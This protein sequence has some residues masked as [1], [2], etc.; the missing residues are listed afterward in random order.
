MTSNKGKFITNS[1]QYSTYIRHNKDLYLPHADLA[2]YQKEVYN[3]DVKIFSNLPSE[4]KSASDNTKRFK[5]LLIYFLST[6]S[7]YSLDE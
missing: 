3:S 1:D 7:F 6:R 2:T 5:N 4:I